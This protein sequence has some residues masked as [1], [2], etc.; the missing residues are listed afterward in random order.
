M[1]H[2]LFPIL[3]SNEMKKILSP[4]NLILVLIL[5]TSSGLLFSSCNK[6]KANNP[7]KVQIEKDTYKKVKSARLTKTG[8]RLFQQLAKQS[9]LIKVRQNKVIPIDGYVI[10]TNEIQYIIAPDTEES[11][12]KYISSWE[13]R[14]YPWPDG[15][16]L[17]TTCWCIEFDTGKK[18]DDCYFDDSD[19][20]EP[21]KIQCKGGCGCSRTDVLIPAEDILEKLF[22]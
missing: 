1:K 15:S 14:T 10:W 8:V 12:V 16:A 6:A 3:K 19:G 7:P 2:Y 4:L 17:E 18:G 20:S 5:F 13:R 22:E 9:P 11:P 21:I